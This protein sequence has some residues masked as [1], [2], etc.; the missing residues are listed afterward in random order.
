MAALAQCVPVSVT[1]IEGIVDFAQGRE[2]DLVV[3]G[4]E[5]PLALGIVDAL[6]RTGLV[7]FGPTQ[8]AARVE[9]SKSW[10]KE[11][12]VR[13]G[14]PTAQC[15][16]FSSP[17]EA[18][19][20]ARG[21][22]GEVVVKLDGLA[23]GKG[24]AVAETAQEAE[25][26]VYELC[27]ANPQSAGR[28]L[29]EERLEGVEVSVL[30]ISDGEHVCSLL[31]AKDHKRVGDGDTG[32]NTGGMG[33]VAPS[34]HLSPEGLDRVHREILEPAVAELARSGTPF[35]GVLYAGLM[36]TREGPKVLEFNCRF[37]DPETEAILPLLETDLADLL[38]AACHGELAGAACEFQASACVSVVMASPGYP[39][40]YPTGI[41]IHLPSDLPPEVVIFHAGT[42]SREGVLVSAGGRVLAVTATGD[43]IETARRRAYAACSRVDFPDCHFRRDIGCIRCEAGEYTP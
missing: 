34:P 24:V 21:M 18:A 39:G 10:A 32:P 41:P 29:L 23:G 7:A 16:I 6:T 28:I 2:C 30:G 17:E 4:P 13:A 20:A 5:A 25:M 42:S 40:P 26:A 11:L 35:V 22:G 19:A 37:G 14:I 1:D 15:Q 9:S 33:A 43:I 27:R 36:L 3:V 12:M 8:A 38:L 31:P